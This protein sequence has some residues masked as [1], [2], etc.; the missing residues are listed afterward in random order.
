MMLLYF[1]VEH[2]QYVVPLVDQFHWHV[3]PILLV[4]MYIGDWMINRKYRKGTLLCCKALERCW[5]PWWPMQLYWSFNVVIVCIK[6]KGSVWMWSE[7]YVTLFVWR[8]FARYSAPSG[9]IWLE[10]RKSVVSVWVKYCVSGKIKSESFTVFW[11]KALARCCTPWSEIVLTPRFSVVSVCTNSQVSKRMR[12]YGLNFTLFF[13]RTLVR[14]CA[15][16]WVIWQFWKWSTMS[17]CVQQLVN[18]K[19]KRCKLSFTSFCSRLLTRCCT[20]WSPISLPSHNSEMNVC[21]KWIVKNGM[22]Q[23]IVTLVC[24]RTVARLCVPCEPSIVEST[25]SMLSV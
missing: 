2:W 24:C 15:P 13:S 23:W 9:P 1:V 19:I 14:Y 12:R 4:S 3:D 20:P 25:Q 7:C 11:R 8:A 5:T 16:W 22:R 10:L 21:K 6:S 18:D 17:V